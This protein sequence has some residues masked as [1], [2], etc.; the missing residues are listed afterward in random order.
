MLN[1]KSKEQISEKAKQVLLEADRNNKRLRKKHYPPLTKEQL[2]MCPNGDRY[3]RICHFQPEELADLNEKKLKEKYTYKQIK[4]YIKEI[5]GVGVDFTEISNHFNRHVL[6]NE[7]SIRAL[8]RRARDKDETFLHVAK[9]LEPISSEVKVTTTED[10]EKAYNTIVKMAKAYVHASRKLNDK[11]N[12]SLVNRLNSGE[13]ER[14]IDGISAIELLERVGKINK[15]ARDF[16]A[17]VN[18]LRAPK[19]MVAQFLEAFIDDVIRE[20]SKI[21]ANMCG[22]LQYELIS[23][24]KESGYVGDISPETFANVFKK[25]AL[26]YRDRIINVKR[27]KMADAVTALQSLEKII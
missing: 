7:T 16:I 17:D 1:S 13:V 15:E 19:V 10:L 24:I 20:F 11:I 4:E 6:G 9:A 8:A 2:L 27:N 18:K 23:T 12:I 5:R 14:E 21:L 25:F 26:D 3:C 22:E